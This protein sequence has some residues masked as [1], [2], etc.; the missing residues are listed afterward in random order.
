MTVMEVEPLP[1]EEIRKAVMIK[2]PL[3]LRELT[4]RFQYVVTYRLSKGRFR[5][6]FKSFMEE[7]GN[8]PGLIAG[9]WHSDHD[10]PSRALAWCGEGGERAMMVC[11][12]S[13]EHDDS[14]IYLGFTNFNQI[15]ELACKY[16]KPT[17]MKS[18]GGLNPWGVVK[19]ELVRVEVTTPPEE[20]LA[21][22][23]LDLWA[24]FLK[25]LRG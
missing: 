1:K 7:F 18:T 12:G 3:N 6:L 16:W 15:P 21:T 20:I 11:D 4:N 17:Q 25:W 5:E 9:N 8:K 2:H 23:E 19:D 10:G 14:V 13:A 24:R 22:P